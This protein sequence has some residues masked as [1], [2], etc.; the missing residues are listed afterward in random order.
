MTV[1][2]RNP[3]SAAGHLANVYENL[4][5]A[6]TFCN[7]ARST[8][9]LQDEC[10]NLLLDPTV[11]A[12]ADHFEARDDRLVPKTDRGAYAERVYSIN[13]ELKTRKRKAR[14]ENIAR[15]REWME[16]TPVMVRKLLL[17]AEHLAT[18]KDD[19]KRTRAAEMRE[20]AQCLEREAVHA[21]Q[22]MRRYL[23][24]PEQMNAEYRCRC[25]AQLRK[26]PAQLEV[27]LIE[28]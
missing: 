26:L 21:A 9:P 18:S 27:Q 4:L 13:A 14:R 7:R 24:I 10:G 17:E 28:L 20:L 8:K 22:C 5:Y 2:H 16:K 19:G 11:D 12:W 15:W 6:C 3:Q 1:E 23:G 25:A